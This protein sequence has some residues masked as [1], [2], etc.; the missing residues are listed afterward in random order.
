LPPLHLQLPLLHKR[1]PLKK[2]KRKLMPSLLLPRLLNQLPRLRQ[3]RL[4]KV[5]L[6]RK[7]HLK[8]TQKPLL[9][10]PNNLEDNDDFVI[11]DEVTFGRNRRSAEFGKL[12]HDED[13]ELSEYVQDRLWLARM[14]ALKKHREIWG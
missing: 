7:T 10:Q 4:Q 5:S 2:K 9:R 1:Q 12:V 13:E 8:Q 6:P 11:D 14:L 3:Q